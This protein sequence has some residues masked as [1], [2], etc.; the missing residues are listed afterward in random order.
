MFF[1]RI[2]VKTR[3][4]F[5]K[6]IGSKPIR[7]TQRADWHTLGHILETRQ[8]QRLIKIQLK[9]ITQWQNPIAIRTNRFTAC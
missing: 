3:Q 5:A 4:L 2:C 7:L 8:Q 9:T 1:A 6:T